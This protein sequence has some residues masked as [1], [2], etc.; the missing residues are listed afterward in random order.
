MI[1]SLIG[2]S[3]LLVLMGGIIYTP[4]IREHYDPFNQL[5]KSIIESGVSPGGASIFRKINLKPLAFAG[6]ALDDDAQK[7]CCF[8][9]GILGVYG[10]D[11]LL[12]WR[13]LINRKCVARISRLSSNE[14]QV[15]QEPD[16]NLS[17]DDFLQTYCNTGAEHIQLEGVDM[18]FLFRN[19]NA[20]VH[21]FSMIEVDTSDGGIET[22]FQESLAFIDKFKIVMHQ[23]AR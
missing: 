6:I 18:K 21:E 17:L 22:A 10:Y 9:G 16:T 2:L 7:I 19:L 20:P 8:K 4:R 15:L 23:G 1:E 5:I 14:L 13:L 11:Q 12:E 3:I